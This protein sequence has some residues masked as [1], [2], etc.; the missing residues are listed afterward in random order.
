M[1]VLLLNGS[2]HRE[3]NTAFAL[4]QM[5][6]IFTQAGIETDENFGRARVRQI[7]TTRMKNEI[8]KGKVVTR[9]PI[10][11]SQEE[12]EDNRRSKS[13]KLRIFEKA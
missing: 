13:A 3:G 8:S 12:L 10:L 1:K 7:H 5:Q 6:E 2:P 11:P 9:K 4:Q